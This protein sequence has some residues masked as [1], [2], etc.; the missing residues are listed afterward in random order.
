MVPTR[1]N[2]KLISVDFSFYNTL[3]TMTTKVRSSKFRHLIGK[4]MQLRDCYNDVTVG[5]ISAESYVIKAN[6]D[7]FAVP[8]KTAGGVCVVPNGRNGAIPE[9][10][11][12]IINI[13]D[14]GETTTVNE[15][16]FSPHE[17]SLL[18]IAGQDGSVGLYRIPDGGLTSD[19]KDVSL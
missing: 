14:D 1:K 16:N 13:N 15:F 7:Y 12:L 5:N 2:Q 18:A 4:P 9:D 3:F 17:N 11:P 6:S 19:L 10:T 8:W